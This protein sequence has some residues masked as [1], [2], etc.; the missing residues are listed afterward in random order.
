MRERLGAVQ[1]I[2]PPPKREGITHAGGRQ[3]FK[4]QMGQDARRAR[5]PGIGNDK[6]GAALMQS[7][8]GLRLFCLCG[9][10]SYSVPVSIEGMPRVPSTTSTKFLSS[11]RM[12]R[13][14]CAISKFSRASLSDFKR[15]L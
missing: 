12:K 7:A 13:L 10:P 8:E 9:H 14:A 6:R 5:V 1:S 3:S 4:S 2:V 11:R 15:A